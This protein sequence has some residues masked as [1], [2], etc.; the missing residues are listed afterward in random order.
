MLPED[1]RK[2]IEPAVRNALAKLDAAKASPAAV[3]SP[4][5]Q[6]CLYDVEYAL[7]QML[8]TIHG[9]LNVDLTPALM[10]MTINTVA[11]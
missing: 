10:G 8:P 4:D 2:Q 6:R 7:G 11:Q 9:R 3:L 1:T 5:M